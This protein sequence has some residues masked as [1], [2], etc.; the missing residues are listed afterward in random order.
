MPPL[1]FETPTQGKA[2]CLRSVS[3]RYLPPRGIMSQIIG[4]TL[5]A[6][7]A[8][9]IAGSAEA[10]VSGPSMAGLTLSACSASGPGDRPRPGRPAGQADDGN[11][12]GHIVVIMQENHSFDHYFG[13]LN[14]AGY[15]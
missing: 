13:R 14:R 9:L 10:R 2:R 3:K 4:A 15:Y 12:I 6:I 1:Q 7:S 5:A 8:V 11:P